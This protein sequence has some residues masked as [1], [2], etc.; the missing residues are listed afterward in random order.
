MEQLNFLLQKPR[1]T[2]DFFGDTLFAYDYISTL[3]LDTANLFKFKKIETPFFED[4]RLFLKGIGINTDIAGKEMYNLC[5]DDTNLNL[6]LRPEFTAGVAR[7][8]IEHSMFA[9][10][11]PVKLMS[12]GPVFRHERPQK[13]RFRDPRQLNLEIIG[14][15]NPLYDALPILITKLFL[16]KLGIEVKL[17]ISSTGDEPCRPQYIAKLKSNL[18]E[19]KS[20]LCADCQMRLENN[21]LRILDCK[22]PNCRQIFTHMPSILD[23]L[24]KSCDDH[25]KSLLEI[26]DNLNI[27]YE[28]DPYLVRGLNYYTKTVFEFF[29]QDS[30]LAIGGGGRYD[31]LLQIYGLDPTPAVGIALGLDRIVE[32]TPQINLPKA[33]VS[34]D[35]FLVIFGTHAKKKAFKIM[36]NLVQNNISVTLQPDKES[37]AAQLKAADKSGA[38]YAIIIGQKEAQVHQ[39]ILKDMKSGTQDNVS[40]DNLI[41]VL[42]TKL[43]KA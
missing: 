25:L 11:Q 4:T 8:Y 23:S 17:K 5:R 29:S 43:S 15:L 2:R 6:S 37:L 21:T 7:A 27:D 31:Y 40:I 10:S 39:I 34:P 1:G 26:L 30:D 13:G 42:K 28:I 18:L 12:M 35:I 36:L 32:I 33:N 19:F 3:F 9:E 20:E 16:Q 22:N 41:D 38:K 24:C 14:S